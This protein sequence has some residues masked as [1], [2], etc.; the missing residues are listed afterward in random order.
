[1]IREP[2]RFRVEAL[3]EAWRDRREAAHLSARR[4]RP[5]QEQLLRLLHEWARA[6]VGEIRDVYG[7]ELPTGVE[8]A[9]PDD[10]RVAGAFIVTIG[11]GTATFALRQQRGQAGQAWRIVST[12][13]VAGHPATK[14]PGTRAR[15]WTRGKLDDIL[16]ALLSAHER[17]LAPTD[18]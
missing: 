8:P 13:E 17:S 9:T 10:L 7:E 4:D 14:S 12:V 15:R 16:L 3:R 1:M 18:S 5:A 6:S 11:Q 2:F